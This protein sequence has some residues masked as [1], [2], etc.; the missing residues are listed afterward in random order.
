[1]NFILISRNV[2]QLLFLYTLLIASR[3]MHP[4]FVTCLFDYYLIWSCKVESHKMRTWLGVTYH[5]YATGTVPIVTMIYLWIAPKA[6]YD[7]HDLLFPNIALRC[8]ARSYELWRKIVD[9]MYKDW[10][11]SKVNWHEYQ[12][13]QTSIN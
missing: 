10:D 8:I 12:L 3:E 1:M 6:S 4:W 7:V 13:V 5:E 2:A 9:R 11:K